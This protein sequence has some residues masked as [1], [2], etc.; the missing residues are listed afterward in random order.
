MDFEKIF[1]IM[2]EAFPED[3][4]RTYEG[5]KRLL[6]REI[7]R[8][9]SE[10]DESG[11]V[12]GFMTV[13][14]LGDFNFIEHIAVCSS[15]RGMGIGRNIIEK[16]KRQDHRPIILEVEPPDN[17]LCRRRI[18]FYQRLGFELSEFY[19]EQPPLRTGHTP[20]ALQ[21]MSYPF[22]LNI[23]NFK[24]CVSKLYSEVY[25]VSVHK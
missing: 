7:Y 19:Y 12:L 9:I 18:G 20:K 25:G 4:F 2:S 11:K 22:A 15:S 10:K 3:E 6:N 8:I 16:F 23:A 1:A 17:E 24:L 5:Q 13:W 14:D 21:L